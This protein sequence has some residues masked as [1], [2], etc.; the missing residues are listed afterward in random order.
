[1]GN[2]LR[3]TLGTK[4]SDTPPHPILPQKK[5][6]SKSGPH[7]CVL[8]HRIG[9]KNFFGLHVFSRAGATTLGLSGGKVIWVMGLL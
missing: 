6:T 9:C 7:G 1:M 8:A 5:G 4:Q 3:N 2:M